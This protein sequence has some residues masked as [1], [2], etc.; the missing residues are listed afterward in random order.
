MCIDNSYITCDPSNRV[1]IE[2]Y[3]FEE[4]TDLELIYKMLTN[5]P[6]KIFNSYCRGYY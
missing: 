5:T 1:D 6:H 3:V 2:I 4:P